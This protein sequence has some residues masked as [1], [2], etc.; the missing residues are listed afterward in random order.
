VVNTRMSCEGNER[1][2]WKSVGLA[3][4]DRQL[5]NTSLDK[6]N[7]ERGVHSWG[8]K[9]RF[10]GDQRDPPKVVCMREGG[11]RERFSFTEMIG[12]DIRS[13]RWATEVTRIGNFTNQ[14]MQGTRSTERRPHKTACKKRL[15][16]KK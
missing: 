4:M 1:D 14:G 15:A 13:Q 3:S 12:I 16:R 7:Q 8:A 9:E 6:Q 11:V 5:Q 10:L 2:L